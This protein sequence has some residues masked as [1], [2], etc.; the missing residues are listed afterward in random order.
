MLVRPLLIWWR[1]LFFE[2]NV[3]FSACCCCMIDKISL[4]SLQS[5]T[6]TQQN[7]KLWTWDL[8]IFFIC[9]KKRRK[10][11]KIKQT[12]PRWRLVFAGYKTTNDL[13]Q[14]FRKS[15]TSLLNSSAYFRWRLCFPSG[16]KCNLDLGG[17]KCFWPLLQ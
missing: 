15:S 4:L 7:Y 8:I 17:E 1:S 11:E 13:P 10:F 3:L 12:Y 9:Q 16:I 2:A 5:T 14:S 6:S